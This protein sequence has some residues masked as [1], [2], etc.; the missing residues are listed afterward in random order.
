MMKKS[1]KYDFILH[2]IVLNF[3]LIL[4]LW[5]FL[6]ETRNDLRVVDTLNQE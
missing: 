2:N 6:Y 3:Q 5:K 4:I 1:N